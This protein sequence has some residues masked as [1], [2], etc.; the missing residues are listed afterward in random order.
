MIK[1]FQFDIWGGFSLS[2]SGIIM[3]N[4]NIYRNNELN[5]KI[6]F[7]LLMY[8]ESLNTIQG[9]FNL[10][11]TIFEESIVN[12]DSIDHLKSNLVRIQHQFD[13]LYSLLESDKTQD[14]NE[15]KAFMISELSDIIKQAESL[16]ATLCSHN[17]DSTITASAFVSLQK[18]KNLARKHKKILQDL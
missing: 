6:K 15:Q 2:L 18:L 11:K 16:E 3:T 17:N 4:E 1:P 14:A 8:K 5:R 7:I 12:K 9:V 13:V 10:K